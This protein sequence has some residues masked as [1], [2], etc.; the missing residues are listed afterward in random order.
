[1]SNSGKILSGLLALLLCALISLMS[2]P[3]WI[4]PHALFSAL[5]YPDPLNASDIIVHS[6]RLTR[7]LM[8]V[9]V[10][11]FLA[12]AGA[13]MQALT[14]NPVASPGLFGINA[15]ATF[16]IVVAGSLFSLP[17]QSATLLLAFG[18]AATASMMVWF[19]SRVSHGQLNPLRL[20]LAGVAISALFTA[21]SQAILVMN[22][23]GLDTLLFWLAGS[24]T[25]NDI[26]S[27]LPAILFGGGALLLACLMGAKI[28]VLNAGEE[29]AT[30][31]GLNIARV[32]LLTSILVVCLAG[33]AVALAGNIGFVGLM[34]PHITRKLFGSDHR[35]ML[36]ACALSGAILLLLADI[37]ARVVI[38]PQEVPVGVMTALVGAPF[39]IWLARKGAN[40]D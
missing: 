12:V 29:V 21:F 36:P 40:R 4:A 32:R 18:G 10:G 16:F 19:A 5:F 11:A 13:L 25:S 1:M 8:A 34:V 17:G 9:S 37:L 14:R 20:V 2:G 7:T 15:G 23:E 35:L 3:F 28:N 6:S 27:Q 22:Q 38:I 30:G 33:C 24:L 31:L 39:F 26:A